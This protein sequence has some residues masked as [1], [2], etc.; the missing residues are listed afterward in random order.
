[1]SSPFF[2]YDDDPREANSRKKTFR[3]CNWIDLTRRWHSFG[4]PFFLHFYQEP[5]RWDIFLPQNPR[6]HD[7]FRPWLKIHFTML[8]TS[9][10]SILAFLP[11]NSPL[12]ILSCWGQI[13][14][15]QPFQ[16]T[17]LSLL[18]NEENY[19]AIHFSYVAMIVRI[20]L[21]DSSANREIGAS[22]T[23]AETWFFHFQCHPTT[24]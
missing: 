11:Q 16:R 9:S 7:N 21:Q 13:Y 6:R 18:K 14:T 20:V 19:R 17:H 4:D 22:Y 3:S 15:W 10:T 5:S 1:M 2:N 8:A 12:S 23:Q 24:D